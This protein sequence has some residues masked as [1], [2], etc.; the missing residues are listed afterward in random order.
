MKTA[1]SRTVRITPRS[2]VALR[3]L[4]RQQ[5]KPMQMILDE[6][7]E[8]YQRDKFLDEVNTAFA[9]LR[10]NRKAWRK[11]QEERALWDKAIADGLDLE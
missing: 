6:A 10:K 3:A 1:E 2:K 4:A 5:G 7:I 9:A 11:E 8:S